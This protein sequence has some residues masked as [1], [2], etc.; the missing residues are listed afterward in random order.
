MSVAPDGSPVP[1]YLRLPPMGEPELI[2]AA[3]PAGASILELGCGAGRVTRPLVE[4]G[5]QVTAVDES[6]EMLTHVRGATTV[7]ANVESLEL[8][9]TF[10]CVLL[11][12]H[13][14]NAPAADSRAALL[15][16]C[17]RHVAPTGAVLIETYP[18]ELEWVA[19]HETTIGDVTLRL[20]EAERTGALVRATMEYAMAGDVWRQPFEA[21]LL[22][23][24]ELREELRRASLRFER[25]L[26]DGRGW[27]VARP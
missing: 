11:G 21:L 15:A 5:F 1:V 25:W 9:Q 22:T 19:G 26:D 3:I 18:A 4:L 2:A 6:P 8:R 23:E 10:D 27:F 20:A 12:S 7:L 14:I 16:S 17:A 24:T 13:F